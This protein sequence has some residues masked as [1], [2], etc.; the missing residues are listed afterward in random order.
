M[1]DQ[2]QAHAVAPA[3]WRDERHELFRKTRDGEFC[4]ERV[5]RLRSDLK[6]I[7]DAVS[8][9]FV[10]RQVY[11]KIGSIIAANAELQR[12]N[13]F[14]AELF[15]W[16]VMAN[17]VL[18]ERDAQRLSHV[19]SL[20]NV[21]YEIAENPDELSRRAFRR[22]HTGNAYIPSPKPDA[23]GDDPER[24]DVV[25]LLEP[26]Y[27]CFCDSTNAE[28]L[29]VDVVRADAR[30]LQVAA[31]QVERFRNQVAGH[32]AR[33]VSITQISVA[34]IHGYI[35]VLER[36][37]RKYQKLLFAAAPPTLDPITLEDWTWIF[38]FPWIPHPERRGATPY[39]PT[40]DLAVA[41]A[42]ALPTGERREVLR[43]LNA[44]ESE[45]DKRG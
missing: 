15:E 13:L 12:P 20:A 30:E 19:V 29:D 24:D 45:T 5:R 1:N 2:P 25:A 35:D 41:M 16:Y 32:R 34:E 26:V 14:L 33:S 6:T 10:H 11:N 39:V 22:M 3:K 38:R 23:L 9:L 4:T 28:R 40:V 31:A 44:L 36:L 43:K 17:I 27:D 42:R 37:T 8:S 7:G 18:A 21:L